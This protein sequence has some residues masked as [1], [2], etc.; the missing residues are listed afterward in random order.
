MHCKQTAT[1][2]F[3]PCPANQRTAAAFWSSGPGRSTTTGDSLHQSG[4]PASNSCAHAARQ[5]RQPRSPQS[6]TGPDAP[7]PSSPPSPPNGTHDPMWCETRPPPH[8]SL[9]AWSSSPEIR[10]S[11]LSAGACPLPMAS[12]PPGCRNPGSS[13]GAGHR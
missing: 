1:H 2:Q 12:V 8:S 9:T 10:R 5:F 13:P 6:P 3:A 11:S 7:G 4:K